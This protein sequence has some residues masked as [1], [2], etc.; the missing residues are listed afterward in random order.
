[1]SKKLKVFHLFVQPDA[2]VF[3]RLPDGCAVMDKIITADGIIVFVDLEP[4][5]FKDG[6]KKEKVV[7][8]WRQLLPAEFEKD[9]QKYFAGYDDSTKSI[10][11]LKFV[12]EK[13]TKN[14]EI[15]PC[16]H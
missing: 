14:Q 1:M 3:Y 16:S 11:F 12:E 5:F 8:L 6:K 13:E 10:T 4:P 15:K 7:K 2:A 9:K